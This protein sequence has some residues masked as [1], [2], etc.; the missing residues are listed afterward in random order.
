MKRRMIRLLALAA[1]LTEP[2][3][4]RAATDSF[5]VRE[6]YATAA[7]GREWSSKWNNGVARTFTGVDPQDGW[8]DAAHGAATYSVDGK[9]L[10]KITGSTPR[11]YVHDPA[12][13]SSWRN[14]EM[15]VY[16]M[17]VADDGTAFAGIV[18]VARS[19]HG[20]TGAELSNLC[21]TR[22]YGARM[23]YD[24]TVDFDKETSHPNATAVASKPLTSGGMPKN[25]WIGYKYVV[26]DL[27]D[28]NVK[29]EMYRDTTD[30]ASGGT[31]V[32]VNEYT[33]N[34]SNM[35][36]GA[37]ACKSGINPALRLTASDARL[38]SESGK[39]NITV[40][41]R[42]TNVGTNGLVYKKMSVREITTVAA[43]A[44]GTTAPTVSITA[45]AGGSTVS[46]TTSVAASASDD[47]GVA[48]VQFKL[49]GANLG[50]EDTAAPYAVSWNT[51]GVSN[52]A[53]ALTAV[54][55][56]AAGNVRTSA[57]V[58]VSVNNAA[59]PLL[60]GVNANTLTTNSAYIS[61]TTDQASD[62][63]VEYGQ[64]SAYGGTSAGPAG[65][66]TTHSV[67]VN[68]LLSGTA[69]HV[70]AKSRNSAG[71]QGVSADV[72]F[73]TLAAAPAP[74]PGC[75]TSAGTWQNASFA[76]QSGSFTAQFDATPSAGKMDGVFGLARTAAADYSALAAIV[77]FNNLGMIDARNGG[78]YA[79]SAA[80]A[81]SAGVKYHL[82]LAV[83]VP[84]HVYSVYVTAPGGAEQ[85]LA[86]NFAFRSEQA[87][88][89]SLSDLGL[90]T[91][92][93]G[94]SGCSLTVAANAATSA[95]MTTAAAADGP[96]AQTY[97]TAAAAPAPAP[98][99][100][101]PRVTLT[102]PTAGTGLTGAAIL[103]AAASD[104]VAVAG[105]QFLL[106]GGPL[107]PELTAA[108]YQSVW[109]TTGAAGGPHSLMA[110]A[111]DAAGNRATSPAVTVMV[112]S[113]VAPTAAAPTQ[114]PSTDGTAATAPTQ[115]A[116][117]P[118]PSPAPVLSGVAANS[119]T[120]NS[121]YLTW[122]TDQAADAN[123]D[124]GQSSA[125]AG[126]SAGPAGLATSHTVYVN[127]LLPGTVYHYRARSKNAAGTLGTSSDMTFKTQSATPVS[128]APISAATKPAGG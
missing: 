121:V 38:G 8:F 41:W 114:A 70:R 35:G 50:T 96:A 104:N 122:A 60:S 33:D 97:A 48:G 105:V 12:K 85:L 125:Y 101:A 100:T 2:L 62:S 116:S 10:F 47:V 115:T 32:K 25:V 21:D 54:A 77:R 95:V 7:G 81:Y 29:L 22:G 28:G 39:P 66:S 34:G 79:A 53:H 108:P 52:G 83:N 120:A 9:G 37:V 98:D 16:A 76:P 31:W 99:T 13:A 45:P 94:E 84:A 20:T 11:M 26:Y 123:V 119:I 80:I 72:T 17:R 1:L 106:D 82:R 61:W 15:T 113:A 30:G 51:T 65:L 73:T 63:S 93:G 55:R 124:Y 46:G 68:G 91:T 56:D 102:Q 6:V 27:P 67:Y 75:V 64:S 127:G 18:G 71:L 109:D 128:S 43:P 5:G 78:A 4:A 87:A 126:K 44:G 111:R 110:V 117:A 90:F 103:A 57:A 36:V 86:S 23:R 42:S 49:D 118:A 19:N 40:Y 107:G 69:Y 24:G 92:V 89:M 74:A 59:A 58:T 3:A 88:A 112:G 14:V